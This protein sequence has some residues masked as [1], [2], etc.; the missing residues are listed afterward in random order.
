MF[1]LCQ[2]DVPVVLFRKVLGL[3]SIANVPVPWQG[4]SVHWLKVSEPLLDNHRRL[5][6][7]VNCLAFMQHGEGINREDVMISLRL[8]VQTNRQFPTLRTL[9]RDIGDLKE[10]LSADLFQTLVLQRRIGVLGVQQWPRS[11]KDAA[12]QDF[13]QDILL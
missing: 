7:V 9:F 12:K 5:V 4:Q 11:R 2:G 13:S 6:R 8:E 3:H 1:N 10:L